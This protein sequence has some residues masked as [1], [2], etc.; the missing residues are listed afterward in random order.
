VSPASKPPE[1]CTQCD[2]RTRMMNTPGGPERCGACHPLGA[3]PLPQFR[4]CPRCHSRIY[5][6]DRLPC[7]NHITVR[8]ITGAA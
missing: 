1:W 2:K 8:Q 5:K 3:Q 6:W 4:D 7:G